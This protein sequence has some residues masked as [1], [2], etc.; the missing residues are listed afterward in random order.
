ML[1]DRS[2]TQYSVTH[3][4]DIKC[5]VNGP[6]MFISLIFKLFQVTGSV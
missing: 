4:V 2:Q 6:I 5:I 1:K 3:Y